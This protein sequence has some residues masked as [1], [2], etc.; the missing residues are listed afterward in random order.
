MILS[1]KLIRESR[2]AAGLTQ[3]ELARRAGTSQ[4]TIAAY[5][6]GDKIPRVATLERLLQAAGAS[7][8]VSRPRGAG[9][10][11][12]LR[13]LLHEH[14]EE[15]LELAADHHATNVRVFG[16]VARGEETGR[17]DLDLLVDMEA[18]RSLLDQVRLRRAL[19]D[20]LGVDIDVVASGGLLERDRSS[21]LG[22][23]IAI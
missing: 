13:R 7:L 5:E 9:G 3:A 17:S 2:T 22:E 1:A 21:I 12:R 18:G 23:A 10:R 6:A 20:L 16:S 19:T 4:P 8:E 15:I 14:R 11:D